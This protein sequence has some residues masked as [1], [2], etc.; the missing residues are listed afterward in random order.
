MRLR[1]TD[2]RFFFRYC[3]ILFKFVW[4]YISTLLPYASILFNHIT[5]AFRFFSFILIFLVIRLKHPPPVLLLS[6]RLLWMDKVA[7]FVSNSTQMPPHLYFSL[8]RHIH[9]EHS[10]LCLLTCRILGSILRTYYL[11][12]KILNRLTRWCPFLLPSFQNVFISGFID[13]SSL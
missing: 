13:H 11:P 7:V 2:H 1:S 5:V 12:E 6:S 10:L 3:V 8:A 9:S 4:S